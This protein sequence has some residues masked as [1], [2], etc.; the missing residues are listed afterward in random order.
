VPCIHRRKKEGGN[1]EGYEETA[2]RGGGRP[3]GIP[4]GLR[5]TCTE[6]KRILF[7]EEPW[8]ICLLI[9]VS[10]TG[11]VLY[12]AGVF[13]K[14]GR[15]DRGESAVAQNTATRVG[16]HRGRGEV[17]DRPCEETEERVSERA[18]ET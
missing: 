8:G 9:V 4:S 14:K 12:S 5:R 2:T 3:E 13:S 17:V 6:R 15:G 11:Q 10:V 18:L 7:R 1:I 16:K